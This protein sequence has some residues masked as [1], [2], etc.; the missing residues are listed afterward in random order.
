MDLFDCIASRRSV[1]AYDSR[2][3]EEE[4]L[5]KLLRA[6]QAAPTACNFQPFRI[7]VLRTAG[8]GE[9][10]KRIYSQPWFAEAPL[11][12][13]VC[14][15]PGSAWSRRD[16]KN[17]ADVDAAIV[18]DH[19]I[20]A[21]TALGLGTCWIGAFDPKAARKILDLEPGWEPLAFTPLGYAKE[22]P[23][24]RPRKTLGELMFE[25]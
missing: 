8:R 21:A 16:G 25:K 13:L 15:L 23:E 19:I 12:L 4:K 10:L 2:P 1:R 14:S 5:Q 7:V 3:V 18:M 24:A 9:E 20:L 17:Y 22:S 11:A 6:A